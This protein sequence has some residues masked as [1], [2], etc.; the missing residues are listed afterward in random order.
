LSTLV[1]NHC[2]VSIRH[3]HE[4]TEF[5][6]FVTACSDG[7]L[8]SINNLRLEWTSTEDAQI[9]HN[10]TFPLQCTLK[11]LNNGQGLGCKLA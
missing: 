5:R 11:E 9:I 1:N 7:L 4:G 6:R 10:R 2:P 3:S 8:R